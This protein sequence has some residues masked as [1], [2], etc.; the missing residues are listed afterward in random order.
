MP[1]IPSK[2]FEGRVPTLWREVTPAEVV[3]MWKTDDL[4]M[5]ERGH[6]IEERGPQC[7]GLR[8]VTSRQMNQRINSVSKYGTEGCPPWGIP[9]DIR[10]RF[11]PRNPN[12]IPNRVSWGSAFFSKAQ[13]DG[14]NSLWAGSE[15]Y[16]G[17]AE[18]VSY[19]RADTLAYWGRMY[20]YPS[21]WAEAI[22]NWEK[23]TGDIYAIDTK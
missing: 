23:E 6:I 11:D 16:R 9:T 3:G 13:K 8:R 19:Y 18:W 17:S 12:R 22:A 14:H 2:Y 4:A 20:F 7:L 10:W 1:L 21:G 5:R 15:P